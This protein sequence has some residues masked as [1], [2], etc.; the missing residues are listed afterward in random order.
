M[1][2]VLQAQERKEFRG[3]ALTRIRR[4]GNIPAVVYGAKLDSKS[5]YVSEA[6]FTKV[7]RKVGRN[8][9]ISLDLGGNKHNVVLSDY[10]ADPIK[11]EVIHVDFLAVDMSKEITANV[12]INLVGDAPG[13]KDG[14]V[15]QQS[16][17]EL[18]VT[19]TPDNIPQS[20][21][22]DVSNLQVN[23][24]L[25]IADIQTNSGYAIN[26]GVEEVIASILPPRQEAEINSGEEQEP[27]TPDNEEGRETK[28]SE[29]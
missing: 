26:E 16:M 17:H 21:D 22:I 14:G 8:G 13:V 3:S 12:K 5:I 1:T 23:E 15:M 25:T 19:A 2:A 7:I 29:E 4:D 10:Q 6:D 27:G 20:I 24:T 9:V 18:T 11:H 28:S